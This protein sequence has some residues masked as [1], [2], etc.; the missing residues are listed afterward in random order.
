VDIAG[1]ISHDRNP[2]AVTV[3]LEGPP[4]AE[5]KILP[6]LL[7][8]HQVSDFL[9]VRPESSNPPVVEFPRPS[10]PGLPPK[11]RFEGTKEGVF[12]EPVPFI[13]AEGLI[14]VSDAPPTCRKPLPG[15]AKD[16]FLVG[17]NE[18][19]LYATLRK[20]RRPGQIA[21]IQKPFFDKS[22]RTD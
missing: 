22:L 7:L 12:L 15:L 8:S 5:E 17:G 9:D 1:Q 16:F 21:S 19:I 14:I 20:A 18:S 4:L 10:G 3:V 13:P 6:E 2:E 11:E